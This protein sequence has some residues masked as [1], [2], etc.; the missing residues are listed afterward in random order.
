MISYLFYDPCQVRGI[1][2]GHVTLEVCKCFEKEKKSEN[3]CSSFD[4][5]NFDEDVKRQ[6]LLTRVPI[7]KLLLETRTYL[8]YLLEPLTFVRNK[9]FFVSINQNLQICYLFNWFI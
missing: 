1:E 5:T 6:H 4:G 3:E 8:K 9:A 2:P 7:V